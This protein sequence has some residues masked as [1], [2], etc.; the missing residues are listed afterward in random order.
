H[1]GQGLRMQR[2]EGA[3]LLIGAGVLELADP[4]HGVVLHVR[5]HDAQIEL[6]LT[7][8]VHVENRASGALGRA[9]DAV[10]GASLVDEAADRAASGVVDTG[11]PPGSDG[12]ELLLRLSFAGSQQTVGSC[13][14]GCCRDGKSDPLHITFLL[15]M[16]GTGVREPRAVALSVA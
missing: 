13:R 5:L 6:T 12:Y 15:S 10:F 14:K 2:E 4:F 8:R 1:Q 9:A 3:Q 7:N 11:N 16:T